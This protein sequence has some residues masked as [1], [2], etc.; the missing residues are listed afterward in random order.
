MS[1]VGFLRRGQPK[2]TGDSPPAGCTAC[3]DVLGPHARDVARG[4]GHP[5][6]AP[7][8]VAC[9]P[10]AF[11]GGHA[12]R[13]N[14]DSLRRAPGR[15][16]V[17]S[18]SPHAVG[19]ECE[20]LRVVAPLG[21][22]VGEVH[23]AEALHVHLALVHRGRVAELGAVHGDAFEDHARHEIPQVGEAR[24]REGLLARPHDGV[25]H[26]AH[27]DPPHGRAEE[28]LGSEWHGGDEGERGVHVE[29]RDA[30]PHRFVRA[31]AE[32]VA[33]A[34]AES[35]R[36]PLAVAARGQ[37]H[38]VLGTHGCADA[39]P[40]LLDGLALRVHDLQTQGAAAHQH[41]VVE[42]AGQ[43]AGVAERVGDDH[44]LD[45]QLLA[46]PHEVDRRVHV[47][48]VVLGVQVRGQEAL[49]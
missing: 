44:H 40:Q 49:L 7:Q 17:R 33:R 43:A 27:V 19:E 37:V 15:R 11:L 10:Q 42:A 30:R 22:P 34:A 48:E 21:W 47:E 24:R 2:K 32:H 18:E 1:R 41:L 9:A 28:E 36:E 20:A 13:R 12:R 14:G 6:Q 23:R 31:Q 3:S 8:L 39:R 29:I 4:E 45:A 16:P 35:G 5:L 46:A 26:V 38:P 25:L